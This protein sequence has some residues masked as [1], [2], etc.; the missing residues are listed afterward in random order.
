MAWPTT[1]SPK[2]FFVT[3]RLNEDDSARLDALAASLRTTRS[4]VV[5]RALDDFAAA[6]A[7]AAKMAKRDARVQR[8][9]AKRARGGSS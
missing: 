1:S 9:R 6:Q 7:L 5:R 3:L 8:S 2:K 4:E